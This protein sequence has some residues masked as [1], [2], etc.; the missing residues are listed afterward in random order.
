MVLTT[1]VRVPCG[2]LPSVCSGTIIAAG[3][4]AAV[5][6]PVL[7][8]EDSMLPPPSGIQVTAMSLTQPFSSLLPCHVLKRLLPAPL[9]HQHS[10]LGTQLCIGHCVMLS[11]MFPNDPAMV[12]FPA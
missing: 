6:S 8:C 9:H 12:F 5:P 1:A 11:F 4:L 3:S 2:Y 7:L 10:G